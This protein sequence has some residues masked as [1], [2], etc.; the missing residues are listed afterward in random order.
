MQVVLARTVLAAA[1]DEQGVPTLLG[2]QRPQ[3]QAVGF[4]RGVRDG[5]RLARY[6]V[7]RRQGALEVDVVELLGGVSLAGLH[8]D[9]DEVLLTQQFGEGLGGALVV[10][11]VEGDLSLGLLVVTELDVPCADDVRSAILAVVRV[12]RIA[13]P[14]G[15]AKAELQCRVFR[16]TAE[17][18]RVL[19]ELDHLDE[20]GEG[21]ASG[22]HAAF[23]ATPGT[24]LAH[25]DGGLLGSSLGLGAE[26]SND[27]HSV[28]S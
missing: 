20:L 17:L 3:E 24:G 18:L 13:T 21:V 11:L 5:V 27:R 4:V 8:V 9:L 28:T 23:A 14:D 2:R 6:R 10:Q 15:E 12:R 7:E 1:L 19:A 25:V 26:L 22:E 16:L